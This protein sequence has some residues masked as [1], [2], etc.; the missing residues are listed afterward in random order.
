MSTGVGKVCKIIL[1]TKIH[2]HCLIAQVRS[3]PCT[4]GWNVFLA[5]GLVCSKKMIKFVPTRK[6]YLKTISKGR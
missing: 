1:I 4:R 5:V 6:I 2:T 3:K